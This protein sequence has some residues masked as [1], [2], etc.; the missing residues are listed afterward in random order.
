MASP[1]PQSSPMPPPQAPSPMGPPTQSPAPPQSPHS[2]YNQQH[3]NGPPPAHPPSA[4]QPPMQ[5]H[6]SSSGPAH[7]MATNTNGGPQQHPGIPPSGHQMSPHM[8][9][10][11]MPG[12][13][14]HPMNTQGSHQGP[15]GP[16]GHSNM[17]NNPQHPNMPVQGPPHGYMQHQIAHMPPNQGPMTMGSGPPPPGNGPQGPQGPP[18]PLGG[19]PP[20]GGHPQGMPPMPPHHSMMASQ[21]GY[22]H[23]APSAGG[24]PTAP[25]GAPA[26]QVQSGAPQQPP[27]AQTPPHGSA[28]PPSTSANGAPS[29]SPMQGSLAASGPDNL[30]ALQRAIDSMEEKGL[31]EDPRYSQLLAIRAR[32]NPQD[33]NK[34]LFSNNQLSQL[35]A[36]IAAYRKLACNQPITQQIAMMAAGKRTGDTPPECPTP[37]AQPPSPYSQGQ[38]QAGGQGAGMAGGKGVVGGDAARGGGGAPPTPLPMTGQMAP[39]TQPTPPLVNLPMGGAPP[40]RGPAPLRP[41]GPNVGPPTS[42]QPGVPTPGAKQNR[43]TAIPKPVGID[44]LQ[45]LNERENR[46][47]A[48]IAH[49]MEVLSNLPANISDDLRLQAQIEL[50]ALRVLNFQKQLRAEILGQI[51]RDT[52]L[53]TAVNIKAYKRTKRQGL[54]EAR[55]TEKLEKQQKLEAERKRRQK[56]QEFLQSVLQHAKDFKEY[57]RNNVAK[58]SR[59]NKAIMNHHANA[60]REQKK[61][62]ERIE[63]ERMRRLMAEDEEGYRKLIDQKKDKR[64]A[65]LLSQTDEYIASLTEM[66]KQHKQEQRKKQQEEERRKRKSRKKKVLE[67]GEIDALDDSSQSSDSRVSVMDPKTG[68]ILRGEEA[69]LLSQFKDWM[70]T[71]PGWEVLSDSD[72][73]GDDSQ[74]DE[75]R[76]RRGHRDEKSDREKTEEEKAREMIKK[77]KVE[78]DEYKTEEQTYYSIAHTVHESVTEQA[79]ILV[80]GNLKE[81]QIKGLEW[82]VSLFNNN[83]NGILADEMGLGKTIQTIA[84]VTY[85]MEKKKV[86]GP[87]L[88]IVPLSTLS[89]WVLEF[90]KWAPT[91][92]VVSYKGS[93]ASR[94]LVQTQM[95]STKFN[96]LLTTY[97]YVIKD[98]GV[99]AKVQWKYMIIDEG[100]RMKNHHCK[101]TQVLNT[102]YIAPHRLLLTGTPLQNKLPELWALLNFLLPSIFNHCSTFEQWFNAPFATTGEKVELN[103]E[104]TILIIRRLH[105]VL[106]PFLLRRLKKEVESQLPDKVEYIIKCDMSGLQRVLYRHMQSKGVLLTDGSEKGNKGKGGAKALMNT[107]VQLRKLCNHP[108]MFQHIEEKFCDHLG[109]GGGVVSGPDLYRASGKFEMLD[110]ILPKLKKA[111]HRVLM[112]CQMTQC[113][114]I[115]EDYFSWRCFQYLRLDGMTK[116]EDRGELLKKFNEVGSEY[117]I[118]LLST[119]AGGL[120]LNLQSADTVIIFDSDWNPH[121]DLQAQDRA[122]RIGQR[123]EVRVLRLMTVNSVEER[124]LAAA[125]YKLNMDEKVIQAGMFDQKST[126]SERQQF[127]QSILHQDGDDEEEENELPDDD[128]INEMIARS[129]EEM[130]LFKQMD[131]ERKKTET[132][133]RLI[134]ESELPDWLVKNDD[135][136]VCNK[137]QGWNYLDEDETLGRGSRQ[138]KEVDY[139]DS[140]TEKEWLKAID[141][142]FEEEEEEDDDDEVLDKKRKKGRKR[143]RQ[144]DSDEEEVPCSSKKKSKTEINMLKKRLKSIMKKVVDYSDEHR[145]GR[146]LSE[147][148]MKLPS[149]RELPDYYDVIKK[150]LDIKKIMNRIEDGKYMDISDM[151]RDFFT[152]CANAQTYNE[153]ASLIYEDSVRLRNVFIE[154][155]RRY[156][157]GQNSDE[158]DDNVNDKEEEDSDGESNRSVKMKIKLKSKNKSTPSRKRKQRKYVSDDEYFEED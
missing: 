17:P 10:P 119:R 143:R 98:K 14:G 74:D 73:S 27:S 50:R 126:G 9:G 35:K 24:A 123:N 106:R 148:F 128:L 151:E 28:P 1:S 140:L 20:H 77:A 31:Q 100:H 101:L 81:Y 146:V 59:M 117:F 33:P 156:E 62:Q 94:R 55:A 136:V 43:I 54:R 89:N 72:D 16:N 121:Q 41:P 63:K 39:P 97:E 48:R 138:R 131:I 90:E 70:E 83:L 22:S 64:L 158:S 37:P 13:P 23:A 108:F 125:R 122:H 137:G 56:H 149:R 47:A 78:D 2:P 154:I 6:M 51:R 110:R 29:S 15:G 38:A 139:T 52:T 57:H 8:V 113:M 82:L 44:P 124:I 114:T 7:T 105:K 132:Q 92:Q 61:E 32:S 91:V 86:N 69:P 150:P 80:N 30:N 87:F 111:G 21:A 141:D 85:L 118:F 112:F 153:E 127:L 12:P 19:P 26:N 157:N 147:P 144:E 46:I 53:E 79:S 93:P 4:A 115:I 18:L 36:Q 42:Q 3:V 68:E 96:V 133:T 5:N 145:N 99:L 129:E 116:A 76:E 71:H 95:R 102:H 34:G 142:E 120:G 134:D 155:R 60:E 58:L 65:F 49:R 130:E 104:E 25:G 84:L 75:R 45:I 152:L 135:E 67:G 11:H 88:I 40:L 109:T 66:V 103:E 107:I